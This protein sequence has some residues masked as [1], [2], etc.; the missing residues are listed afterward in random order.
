MD[1][2]EHQEAARKKSAILTVYFSLAILCIIAAIYCVAVILLGYF[3]DFGGFWHPELLAWVIGMTLLVIFGGSLIK[4]HTLSKGGEAVAQ[5]L[6]GRKVHPGTTDNLEKRLVNVVEEMAIASGIPIPAVY[7]LDSE[8]AIN[9]FAAGLGTHDA[10]VA[11]TSGTLAKLNRDELQGVVA[12]EFSHILNGDMRLNIRLMGLVYGILVI[13]FIGW[14][15]LRLAARSGR[16]V[17]RNSKGG[18]GAA[19]AFFAM[20]ISLTIIGYIGVFFGKLIK[21]AVS[22]QR[23]FLADASA[24]QFT[25]NPAGIAG[26]LKKIGMEANGSRV[27]NVHAEEAGHLFFGN[28][29]SNAWLSALSTHPPIAERIK[30]IDASF[31]GSFEKVASQKAQSQKSQGK[32]LSVEGS[33]PLAG[34]AA[35][36]GGAGLAALAGEA[37]APENVIERVGAPSFD[38]VARARQL[39]DAI[40]KRLKDAAHEPFGA[41]AVI[42]CLLLNEES[43]ARTIQLNHI[44]THADPAVRPEVGTLAPLVQDLGKEYCLPLADIAL[45]ALRGLSPEQ[46]GVFKEIVSSLCLADKKI[47][48]FEFALQRLVVQRL[49]SFFGLKSKPRIRYFAVDQLQVEVHLLLSA[50]AHQSGQDETLAQQAFA[51]GLQMTGMDYALSILPPEKANFARLNK[52]LDRFEAASPAVH[53]T[54]LAACAA[55]IGADKK[56]SIGEAELFRV[57]AEV[58][59]SPIPPFLPGEFQ[60]V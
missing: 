16:R 33:K 29:L 38:H 40:P 48:L 24:V 15:T 53:K 2:F 56:V 28:A 30:R 42:Y 55:C 52:A 13:A 20:G 39:I 44:N 31:D 47:G 18:G 27:H 3:D 50:L 14:Q 41:M 25:R 35:M 8:K 58:L 7:I 4:M 49:D 12:H 6:G 23:E 57:V 34:A 11:V 26:A 17:S 9:A 37:L 1:F 60:K 51:T 54:I 59:D 5:M 36:G 10:V 19:I 43:E 22:R 32:K 45:N 46:Y 21:S